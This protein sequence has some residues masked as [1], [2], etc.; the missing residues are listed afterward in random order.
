MNESQSPKNPRQVIF[1]PFCVLYLLCAVWILY[2]RRCFYAGAETSL[3]VPKVAPFSYRWNSG[4]TYYSYAYDGG[5][6]GWQHTKGKEVGYLGGIVSLSTM[7]YKS[8]ASNGESTSQRVGM[9]MLGYP[10]LNI[11]Y[12]N[13]WQGSILNSLALGM[14]LEDGGDRYRTTAFQINFGLRQFGFN[15]FTGDPG[16]NHSDRQAVPGE[17]AHDGR[18]VYMSGNSNS[19]RVGTMYLGPI[20]IG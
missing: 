9:V 10:G 2:Q 19:Y 18:R 15:L 8:K 11:K 14:E 1:C 5:V 13:V 4:A 20:R 3:G 6:K 16:L 12:Q 7:E 17:G